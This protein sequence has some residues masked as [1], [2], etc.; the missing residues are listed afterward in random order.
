MWG[1]TVFKLES[2]TL[3][4][5]LQLKLKYLKKKETFSRDTNVSFPWIDTFLHSVSSP[6]LSCRVEF[7]TD[8][9]NRVMLPNGTTG[10]VAMRNQEF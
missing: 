6:R 4:N 2:N 9:E 3:T 10:Q 1:E 7:C 5:K 8:R